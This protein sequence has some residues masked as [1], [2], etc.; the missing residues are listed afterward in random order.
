MK[1]LSSFETA[2]LSAIPSE[3][4]N[5]LP[6]CIIQFTSLET[7]F[8]HYVEMADFASACARP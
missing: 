3:I 5:V 7:E 8:R 1:S 4:E 6:E 2:C